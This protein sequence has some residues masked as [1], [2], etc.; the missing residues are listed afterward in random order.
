VWFRNPCTWDY[1]A[2]LLVGVVSAWGGDRIARW[3]VRRG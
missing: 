2:G 3:L 1:L